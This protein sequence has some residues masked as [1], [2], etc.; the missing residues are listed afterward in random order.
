MLNVVIHCSCNLQCEYV[1][2][3]HF[4]NSYVGQAV[5]SKWNMTSVR[6]RCYSIGSEDLESV[7]DINP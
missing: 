6:A 5:Q 4:W 2:V 7:I 3:G 1:L